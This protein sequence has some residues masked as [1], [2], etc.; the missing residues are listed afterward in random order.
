[1]ADGAVYYYVIGLVSAIML[2]ILVLT[3]LAAK[4]FKSQEMEAW[5][6]VE[7]TEFVASFL[8]LLFALG[9]FEG[10][11]I[12][13]SSF[14]LICTTSNINC[15]NSNASVLD[16]TAYY[17]RTMLSGSLKA[18]TD[19]YWLQ[20]CISIWNTFHK[21]LGEYVLTVSYKV[22]PGIDSY[23][24]LVNT[25]NYGL[26]F[27]VS[28]VNAQLIMITFIQATMQTLFLPAGILLRFFPPTRQAGIFL[29]AFAIG[30]STVFP[31]TYVINQNI[32]YGTLGYEGYQGNRAYIITNVCAKGPYF[33]LGAVGNPGII[34][35]PVISSLFNLVFS[36]L[37]VNLMSPGIF[38]PI[39]DDIGAFSLPSLFLP[40]L[41]LSIT[42]GFING[43]TKFVLMK[44]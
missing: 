13:A 38:R 1:M 20:A 30:F 9:F 37:G 14:H 32:L 24:G 12:F 36:E 4:V 10:A 42:F 39:L 34:T 8:I 11:N 27:V 5:F 40:A 6:N 29:I 44:V 28:S 21:R 23:L 33:I 18:T 17:L 7:L 43:F 22:F 3:Y 16:G 25:I 31:L 2:S 35:I 19:M 26:S 15:T 41:S